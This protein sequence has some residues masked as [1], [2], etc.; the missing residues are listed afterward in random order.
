MYTG[1]AD[2]K[3]IVHEAL[4][5]A[6]KRDKLVLLKRLKNQSIVLGVLDRPIETNLSVAGKG[7]ANLIEGWEVDL[8]WKPMFGQYFPGNQYFEGY[9]DD[10]AVKSLDHGMLSMVKDDMADEPSLRYPNKDIEVKWKKYPQL[11]YYTQFHDFLGAEYV[12]YVRD[13]VDA[14]ADVDALSSS[15]ESALL[16]AVER[17]I[18]TEPPFAPNRELFDIISEKKHDFATMNMPTNK[19]KKT[20]LGEA[21]AT[22]SAETVYKVID[23]GCEVDWLVDSE[24]ITPLMKAVSMHRLPEIDSLLK[25]HLAYPTPPFLDCIRRYVPSLAG[26]DL[27][28]THANF[29]NMISA[30]RHQEIMDTLSGVITK[31]MDE[32]YNP[33]NQVQVITALLESGADPNLPQK[34]CAVWD[35]YTA[36]MLAAELDFYEAFKVMLEYEGNRNQAALYLPHNRVMRC[37]EIAKMYGSHQVLSLLA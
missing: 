37:R 14:G 18:P 31:L 28:S 21:V 11:V 35:E 16:F 33:V 3:T 9:V 22:G 15:G 24:Q 12:E 17:M 6:A 5:M 1:D 34:R 20:I 2:L 19:R 36:L 23:M 26:I 13:L 7:K 30:P 10:E 27:S 4:L 29:M 8:I 32:H 25:Q